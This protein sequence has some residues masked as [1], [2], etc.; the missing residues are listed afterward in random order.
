MDR[1]IP[2]D[3]DTQISKKIEDAVLNVDGIKN[4]TMTSG[5][6]YSA[7]IVEFDFG[8]DSDIKKYS[9]IRNR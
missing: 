4:I 9:S 1:S 7:V 5:L 6:G 8:V 2:E 3:V